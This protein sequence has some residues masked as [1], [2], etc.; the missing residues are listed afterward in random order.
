[1]GVARKAQPPLVNFSIPKP[2]SRDKKYG[3]SNAE[4]EEQLP[5]HNPIEA[6]TVILNS[7]PDRLHALTHRRA[8][9]KGSPVNQDH[10]DQKGKYHR[11]QQQNHHLPFEIKVVLRHLSNR[12]STIYLISTL[13][14]SQ[15]VL[16]LPAS[17][18]QFLPSR[19]LPT[20]KKTKQQTRANLARDQNGGSKD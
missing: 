15:K 18:C 10:Y 3:Q 6:R 1:M 12:W 19:M 20:T 2:S 17:D 7:N 9:K 13:C 8:I 4:P 16:P 5:E 11:R 14:T